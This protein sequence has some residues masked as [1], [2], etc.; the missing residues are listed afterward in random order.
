MVN[1]GHYWSL[2]NIT[3]FST[4]LLQYTMPNIV[5]HK[6]CFLSGIVD[7]SKV[8]VY[9]LL[10]GWQC[11]KHSIIYD[12]FLLKV[13]QLKVTVLGTT[14]VLLQ[15]PGHEKLSNFCQIL[16]LKPKKLRNSE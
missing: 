13:T 2:W 6:L 15:L 5:D 7:T 8:L 1:I 3:L 12:L 4:I 11:S 16:P 14:C 10:C 9:G